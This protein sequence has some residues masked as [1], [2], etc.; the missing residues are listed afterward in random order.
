[1]NPTTPSI[2]PVTNN[3]NTP[4]GGAGQAASDYTTATNLLNN[5]PQQE[6]QSTANAANANT[7]PGSI[8]PN[9]AINAPTYT[10][11]TAPTINAASYG[12]NLTGYNA[13]V[14]GAEAGQ[15][16]AENSIYG[17]AQSQLSSAEQ[18]YGNLTPVYQNLAQEYNIPGYQSD[19]A[20]LSGLLS[21]LNSD[22]NVGTSY[23]GGSTTAAARDE[24]YEQQYQPLENNLNVAGEML[25]YGQQDVSNLLGTY[26]KS[27]TNEL[28][29]LQENI[30]TL[31]TLFG[32]A[33]QQADTGYTQGASAIQSQISDALQAQQ[34]QAEQEQAS[35]AELTA[36]EEAGAGQQPVLGGTGGA[37]TA[38]AQFGF[39]AGNTGAG[40]YYFEDAN[41]T[42]IN[43]IQ[44]AQA[45]GA[46]PLAVIQSMAAN[47][48]QGAKTALA[49]IPIDALQPQDVNSW[50]TTNLGSF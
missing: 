27:L 10:A 34:V 4:F 36:K 41:G 31:P 35:A 21:S 26:E 19:I 46:S 38:A 25:N 28:T 16:S 30:S 39:K 1:M 5:L 18:Q 12:S 17:Q 23:A 43:A 9:I 8:L 48:D 33:N 6:A 44:Y 2:A 3:T 7:N 14:Q 47:G 50:I 37:K 29:P 42:P 15:T 20:T 40:G 32:Q 45:T 11:P 49:S 24:Q 13:A 22:V